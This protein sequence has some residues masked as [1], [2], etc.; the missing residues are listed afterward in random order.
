MNFEFHRITNFGGAYNARP[1]D[2]DSNG[3]LDIFVVS[4]FNM[5][6]NPK[7]QSFIRLENDKIIFTR[8]NIS[9]TPTH[10]LPMN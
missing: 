2:V 9:K 5:W 8:L 6:G 1:Y 4:S 10:L 3:D 7:A